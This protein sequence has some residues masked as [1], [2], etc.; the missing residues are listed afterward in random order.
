MLLSALAALGCR[1]C[2][3]VRMPVHLVLGWDRRAKARRYNECVMQP[4]VMPEM[5][6]VSVRRAC[7]GVPC[8]GDAPPAVCSLIY[9]C[10][11]TG[12]VYTLCQTGLGL[13]RCFDLCGLSLKPGAA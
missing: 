9:M 4:R 6:S 5:P 12:C 7:M 3:N 13:Q 10:V 1:R 2:Y 11:F 8:T